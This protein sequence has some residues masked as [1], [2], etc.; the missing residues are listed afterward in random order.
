MTRDP[1]TLVVALDR[2]G[3]AEGLLYADDER[4]F[5]YLR[6]D[7][8]RRALRFAGGS[9]TSAAAEHDSPKKD[10]ATPP[11]VVERVVIVGLAAKPARCALRD[12][13]GGTRDLTFTWDEA[14]KKAVIRKPSVSVV[15][16]WTISL[17]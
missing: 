2:N 6:G 14:T 7:F 11:N 5:D 4:S 15:A 17:A 10:R 12:A 13:A 3:K 16:D 1:Y 9:L 8:H